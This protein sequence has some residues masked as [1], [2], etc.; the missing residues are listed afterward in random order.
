MRRGL[1]ALLVRRAWRLLLEAVVLL[2]SGM[3]GVPAIPPVA[4]PVEDDELGWVPAC[5]V[6]RP[7]W[8]AE[9]ADGSAAMVGKGRLCTTPPTSALSCVVMKPDIAVPLVV[10]PE[11]V[12]LSEPLLSTVK[13]SEA[14]GTNPS[15]LLTEREPPRRAAPCTARLS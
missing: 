14:A 2:L 15:T 7:V 6:S 1:L 8:M 3:A 4:A 11:K 5:V 12:P 13:L 9:T 10:M